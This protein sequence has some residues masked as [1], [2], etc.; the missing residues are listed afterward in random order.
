MTTQDVVRMKTR[1]KLIYIFFSVN[2]KKGVLKV[3]FCY[4]CVKFCQCMVVQRKGY[5]NSREREKVH[6]LLFRL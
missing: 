3:K 5:Y 4:A 6:I 1:R 2:K